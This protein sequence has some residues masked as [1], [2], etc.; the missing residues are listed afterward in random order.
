MDVPAGSGLG[1]S[2]TLV[3]A[4]LKVYSEMLNIPYGDYDLVTFAFD[5]ERKDLNL[6]GG[7]TSMQHIWWI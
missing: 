5:I 4:I 3:V 7:K 2:S 6:A 1:I